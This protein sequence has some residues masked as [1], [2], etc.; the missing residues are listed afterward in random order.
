MAIRP[1]GCLSP[2]HFQATTARRAEVESGIRNEIDE[3]NVSGGNPRLD[4]EAAVAVLARRITDYLE[5][6]FSI[7]DG[8]SREE[9]EMLHLKAADL[10]AGLWLD[11]CAD[12]VHIYGKDSEHV[13]VVR[14][15]WRE[16]R[17]MLG[18]LGVGK[19]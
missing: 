10:F 6:R 7:L 1:M 18:R 12:A 14:G 9:R 13:Q 11:S 5:D 19:I 16:L 15:N 4:E 2:E 17:E 8:P 3:F